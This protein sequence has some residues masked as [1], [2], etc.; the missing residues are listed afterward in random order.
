MYCISYTAYSI[1]TGAVVGFRTVHDAVGLLLA[2]RRDYFD[3]HVYIVC[4][5]IDMLQTGV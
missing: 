1:R 5:Y 3:T 4:T 2:R